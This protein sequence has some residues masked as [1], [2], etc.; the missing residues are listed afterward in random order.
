MSYMLL[1]PAY[2]VM[3]DVTRKV[4]LALFVILSL[5]GLIIAFA[6]QYDHS[7]DPLFLLVILDGI[8]VA[9]WITKVLP[10]EKI[11]QSYVTFT[12]DRIKVFDRRGRCWREIPFSSITNVRG[13]VLQGYFYGSPS[14]EKGIKY[15]C[16]YLDGSTQ[17]PSHLSYYRIFEDERF[18]MIAWTESLHKHVTTLAMQC[19]WNYTNNQ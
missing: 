4:C 2:K 3:V 7:K 11:S 9:I 19:N 12:F 8:P 6:G 10:K 18:F 16:F 17:K 15:I 13:E 5:F 14:N 1:P